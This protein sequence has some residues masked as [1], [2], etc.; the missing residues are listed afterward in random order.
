LENRVAPVM[1]SVIS[2]SGENPFASESPTPV[3]IFSPQ[4]NLTASG[5]TPNPGAAPGGSNASVGDTSTMTEPTSPSQ[6]IGPSRSDRTNRRQVSK[7][8]Q[9]PT[10][11]ALKT[12]PIR[13]EGNLDRLQ[14]RCKRQGAD[15]GG[16][17]LL[18]KVFA[19]EV[20][21]E[22]LKGSLTDAE[23]HTK[24]LGVET[25]RMHVVFLETINAEEG[26]VPHYVCRLCHA[27]KTWKHKDVL[28]HMR[29][30]RFG[31]SEVC[32]QW[33]VFGRWLTLV[34]IDMSNGDVSGKKF[35]TKAE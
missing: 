24:E 8:Y 27:K 4:A 6:H 21:R 34:S 23:A 2:V 3:G 25:G 10:P 26:G 31:L 9:R 11:A 19:D 12:R 18:G 15:E 33:Y 1:D 7:P 29:R 35:Y 32:E 22:A 5:E 28:Q 14:Q 20:S 13:H 16:I 17:E 30:G